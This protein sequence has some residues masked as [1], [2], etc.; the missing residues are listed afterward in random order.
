[1]K[2]TVIDYIL[3]RLNLYSVI[4][5]KREDLT[6]ISGISSG[7][8][9]YCDMF[10]NIWL[11]TA[12]LKISQSLKPGD[13][14][15]YKTPYEDMELTSMGIIHSIDYGNTYSVCIYLGANPDKR[16][17]LC[18]HF[19]VTNMTGYR[20]ATANEI[21]KFIGNIQRQKN[22]KAYLSPS[23]YPYMKKYIEYYND[24]LKM[25][26]SEYLSFK[27]LRNNY[28]KSMANIAVM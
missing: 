4:S 20:Y 15:I 5:K 25:Q 17:E 21:S 22:L 14:I 10:G 6:N 28:L 24:E 3:K 8:M 9:S 18:T 19:I 12:Q 2:N 13:I 27:D 7:R 26:W 23:G 1:M 11:T 16:N